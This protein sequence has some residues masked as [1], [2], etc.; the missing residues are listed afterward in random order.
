MPKKSL[1]EVLA[2]EEV[3]LIVM[4]VKRFLGKNSDIRAFLEKIDEPAEMNELYD[5]LEVFVGLID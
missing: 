4:L 2:P 5:A 3:L 1:R